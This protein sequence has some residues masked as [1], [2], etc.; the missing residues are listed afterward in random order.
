MYCA[1]RLLDLK[2]TQHIW[3]SLGRTVSRSQPF[4]CIP[5]DLKDDLLYG[6]AI[7]CRKISP[8][9][10]FAAWDRY[11]TYTAVQNIQIPY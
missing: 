5:Q 7:C 8:K 9:T 4:S 3:D 2:P 1:T 10:S 11:R 6:C